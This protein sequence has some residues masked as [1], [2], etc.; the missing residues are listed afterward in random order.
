M[1][2][3]KENAKALKEE[4]EKIGPFDV[5]SKDIGV[6]LVAFALKDSS[7]HTVF[8]ISEHL[9]RFGWIVPAYTMAPDAQHIA[10]LRV[11]IREDFNRSLAE[12]LAADIEKVLIELDAQPSRFAVVGH[13]TAERNSGEAEGIV[14]KKSA[15]QIQEDVTTYWRGLVQKRKTSGVC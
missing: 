15:R 5:I 1:R 10:V 7:K 14:K 8:E 9:R 11:V 3:C 2:N 12:R 4:I 13:V 6:P